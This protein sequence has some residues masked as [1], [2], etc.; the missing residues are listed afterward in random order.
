MMIARLMVCAG[1][2]LAGGS[3]R[4]A[5]QS[6]AAASPPKLAVA[7]FTTPSKLVAIIAN[8]TNKPTRCCAP[9]P[10]RHKL[11]H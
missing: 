2:L 4:A 7:S 5:Q 8:G 9:A 6:P 3:V 10:L 11:N 1:L